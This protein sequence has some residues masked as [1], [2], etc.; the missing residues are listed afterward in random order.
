MNCIL[1]NIQKQDSRMIIWLVHKDDIT[2]KQIL[3]PLQEN[4]RTSNTTVGLARE[5][6]VAEWYQACP[7]MDA[8]SPSGAV[9]AAFLT[10]SASS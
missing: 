10:T 2:K 5:L 6:M 3:I 1:T 4:N 7:I 9:V 8:P